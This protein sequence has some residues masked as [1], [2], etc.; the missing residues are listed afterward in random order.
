MNFCKSCRKPIHGNGLEALGSHWHLHCFNCRTCKKPLLN[1]SFVGFN[2][3]PFHPR[4]LKCPGCRKT[5]NDRYIENDGMPWHPDCYQKQNNPLCAVCRKPLHEYYLMDFWGNTFCDT[6]QDYTTCSSCSR[7]VCKNITDGGMS[8]PDGLVI[9]NLCNLR[10]VVNQEQG[11]RIMEQMRSALSS[12]GLNLHQSNTPLTLCGRDELREASRHN[13]HNERPILGLTRWSTSTTPNGQ[14][15]AREFNDI[16]IQK[17]LPEEHFRTV[18][19]HEL[20]HA[21][22]FYN[23]YRDLPLEVEEG[24]CVMM[25][26]IWLKNQAT[27]DAEFRRIAIETSDDPIYGLGFQKA[28]A[29]LKLM[30]LKTLLQFIKERREFPT[31]WSA[32]FYH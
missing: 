23:N 14:V 12:V 21:W 25:E 17:H 27:K 26:Y 28:R 6:H 11:D 8:F 19:I 9:C 31:R 20:T 10:G 30:P 15:I 2:G 7:I 4:C 24:M 3:R 29:S 5:I 18:A 13:F 1:K 16:L 32:F 22:L